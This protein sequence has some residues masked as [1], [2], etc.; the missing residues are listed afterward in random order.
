MAVGDAAQQAWPPFVL[1]A[2]LLMIGFVAHA[3][4][5]FA[6][7]GRLLEALPGPPAVLLGG[8]MAVVAVVTAVLNLD[9]AVVF[10]TPV[11]VLAARTRGVDEEPFLYAAVYMANASSLYLPGSNLTNLLVLAGRPQPGGSFAAALAAPAAA[12]TLA[13]AVGIWVV[14]AGR[15]RIGRSGRPGAGEPGPAGGPPRARPGRA[16]TGAV[17][18]LA[19]AALTLTL[20]NPAPAVLAVGVL[21]VGIE[22]ARGRLA[23]GGAVRALGP[24]VLGALFV[25]SVGLGALARVWS[26][27]AGLLAGAGRWE[28]AG[29]GALGALSLNNLPATVLLSAQ[30]PAHPRALLIGL[31]LGPNLAVSGSLSAYLWWRAARQVEARPRA[32]AFTRRG[33]VLAPVAIV[34]AL[35][36]STIAGQTPV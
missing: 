32:G 11:L 22:S 19:A 2:G 21:A 31:N 29:I 13:T 7:A 4:G 26:G 6:R 30:A 35:A 20:A 14:F 36:A 24:W 3:D 33:L 1:V 5:L 16:M 12:A 34:A 23:L 9:T 28:T 27:P 10:L 25:A 15:L 17:G 18:A 8:G